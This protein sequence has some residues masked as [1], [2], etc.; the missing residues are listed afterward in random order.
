M[1]IYMNNEF[2]FLAAFAG[3]QQVFCPKDSDS[4][5]RFKK[6]IEEQERQK[7]VD[8]GHIDPICSMM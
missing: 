7:N 4:K 8:D 3:M 2:L 6:F 1:Y 5:E